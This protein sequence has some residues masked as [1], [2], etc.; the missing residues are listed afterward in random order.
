MGEFKGRQEKEPLASPGEHCRTCGGELAVSQDCPT[1]KGQD[2]PPRLVFPIVLFLLFGLP[3]GYLAADVIFT[4]SPFDP[5]NWHSESGIYG[6]G[7][8]VMELVALM[9]MFGWLSFA[10]LWTVKQRQKP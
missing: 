3:V 4:Y 9:V 1:C 6:G 5:M 10:L 7:S 8:N 2:K